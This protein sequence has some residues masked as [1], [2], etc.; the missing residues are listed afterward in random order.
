MDWCDTKVNG[1]KLDPKVQ[2]PEMSKALNNTGK[3]IFFNSCE[4]GQDDPWTWMR[5]YANAWRSGPDHHDVW[6]STSSIIELNNN[7]G[8]YA[9]PGGWNDFDFLM[10]GG[11]GCTDGKKVMQHCPGQ[12]D[13]EY[14]SEFSIWSIASSNLIVATDIR[15]LTS[16]MKQVLLNKEIIEV[17][18]DYPGVG[19]NRVG[20]SNCTESPT[21][22]QIWAK[23]LSDG[24]YAVALYN[25]GKDDNTIYFDTRT[26]NMSTPLVA[27]RDL[28]EHYYLGTTSDFIS[29][30]VG[31][32]DT[33]MF[34]ISPI[35]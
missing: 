24:T 12:T 27:V 28:W 14:R 33:A 3:P 35:F 32:H 6:S 26:L 18:Q 2:Y 13:A 20:F 31:T 25:S 8:Q 4:W 19:G 29:V 10:T 22:C 16:V 9:G 15:N 11:Q 7:R 23:P 5:P 1:T 34:K 30:D 21:A 17:N